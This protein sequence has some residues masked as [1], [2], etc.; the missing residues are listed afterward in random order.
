MGVKLTAKRYVA[1]L[2]RL[3]R[4]DRLNL[5]HVMVTDRYRPPG[6]V[7]NLVR[8]FHSRLLILQIKHNQT[9][10]LQSSRVCNLDYNRM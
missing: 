10:S 9:A 8:D 7:G 2:L 6:R 1:N 4:R 5:N 3:R